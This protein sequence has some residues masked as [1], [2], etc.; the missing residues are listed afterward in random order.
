MP[1]EPKSQPERTLEMRLAELEDKLSKIHVTEEELKAYEKVSALMGQVS[2]GAAP[3]AGG[4]TAS[5]N[6]IVSRCIYNCI[7][8]NC[9]KNCIISN[10]IRTCIINQRCTIFESG[11]C[12]PCAP[13]APFGPMAG[14]FNELGF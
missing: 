4:T 5:I 9:I 1:N 3:A 11:G 10:C 6:C 14:G 2:A 8:S 13:Q 12:G 7:I